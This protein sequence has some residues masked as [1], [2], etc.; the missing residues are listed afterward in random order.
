M[1]VKPEPFSMGLTW[2][3]KPLSPFTDGVT[4][5][6]VLIEPMQFFLCLPLLPARFP[7]ANDKEIGRMQYAHSPARCALVVQFDRCWLVKVLKNCIVVL[8]LIYPSQFDAVAFKLN[9]D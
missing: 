5:G 3:T 6:I 7:L 1:V 4:I 9:G 8:H 2:W